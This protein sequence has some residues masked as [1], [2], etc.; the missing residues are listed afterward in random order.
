M[1]KKKVLYLIPHLQNQGPVIQLYS[2]VKNIDLQQFSLHILTIFPEREKSMVDQFRKIGVE[3]VCGNFEKWRIISQKRFIS[4]AIKKMKP[5]IVHSCSTITDG[6]C[7]SLNIRQ[8]LIITLHNNIYEDVA[9]Q[10]G[11]LVGG[12]LCWK[13]KKAIMEADC[14]VTCSNTLKVQYEKFIPGNYVAIPNGIEIEEWKNDSGLDKNEL[15]EKLGLPQDQFIILSTGALIERKNPIA[16]I[17]A[18]KEADIKNAVLLMLGD[19]NLMEQCKHAA[20]EKVLFTGRV[21]NVKEYLYA[22]DLLISASSAEGMPYA[23]LEAKCTGIPMIL[24]DIPQHREAVK[25][26]EN[27]IAF[28]NVGNKEE[29][30]ELIIEKQNEKSHNLNYHVEEHSAS[31]MGER[32]MDIYRVL[33]KSSKN[34]GKMIGR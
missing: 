13:E 10:Y 21:N 16:V 27:E 17:E 28:F 12:Y 15:R 19:G 31:N 2:L 26:D 33:Y 6:L 18:F 30:R 32:Y 9:V 25:N 1:K 4:E 23:I 34:C 24:S 11:K 5:D 14:V 29:I 3:V 7:A 22:A 20:T 8:P